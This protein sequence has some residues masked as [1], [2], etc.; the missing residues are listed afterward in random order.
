MDT[1]TRFEFGANWTHFVETAL[2][3]RRIAHAVADTKRMLRTDSLTGRRFLDIGCGSGLFSLAAL[4]LGAERVVSFDYDPQSVGASETLRARSGMAP[5]RWAIH[6]GSVLDPEFL[7]TL[8][9]ADIV[10]SWG[11][12][13]HTGDM[14]KA[15]ENAARLVRPGGLFAISIYNRVNR[16]PDRSTMWWNIKRFYVRSPVPVRR[17][18]EW[19]YAL[20]HMATRLLSFRNPLKPLLDRGAGE[21]RRGMDFWHDVRDWLGGFPYEFADAGEVFGFVHDRLGMELVHLRAAEGN[22]CTEFLFRRPVLHD[23]LPER[24]A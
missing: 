1:E 5:E 16:F 19:G 21:D 4:M 8:E 11:V 9:P 14:W 13:H 7:A 17:A 20:N 18:M 6:R 12:L 2:D 3:D 23:T 22:A 10:Y 24:P 15:I